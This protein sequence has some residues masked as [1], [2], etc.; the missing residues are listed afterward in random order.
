MRPEKTSKLKMLRALHKLILAHS[1]MGYALTSCKQI[2]KLKN[3]TIN[4]YFY[5]L[6]AATIIC[7][8]RPFTKNKGTG[9]LGRKYHKF[10]KA[11]L[12]KM[13]NRLLAARDGFIAHSDATKR[14]ASISRP[15]GKKGQGNITVE[16]MEW[17]AWDVHIAPC[18]F[19]DI[20]DLLLEQRRRLEEDIRNMLRS[21]Y[22]DNNFPQK[23]LHIDYYEDILKTE[24]HDN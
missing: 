4:E 23:E 18:R 6:Y 16:Q 21:L 5:P 2:L 17:W 13:H 3:A 14:K 24:Y 10:N 12:S 9:E 22:P 19:K 8:A 20:E 1:D 11:E 15:E 7:Y